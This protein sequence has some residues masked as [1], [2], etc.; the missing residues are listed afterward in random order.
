MVHL[1]LVMCGG[2]RCS[3]HLVRVQRF[4]RVL[5]R[6]AHRFGWCDAFRVSILQQSLMFV[7]AYG[8]GLTLECRPLQVGASSLAKL[9]T[10]RPKLCLAWARTHRWR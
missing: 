5:D 8:I 6:A 4:G 9:E 7:S 1:Y 3:V 2:C 10:M